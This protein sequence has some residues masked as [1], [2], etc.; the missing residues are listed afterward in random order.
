MRHKL[1]AFTLM[2]LLVG[3]VISTI[4]ISFCYMGYRIIYEQY[5]NYRNI[6]TEVVDAMQFRSVMN[7]DFQK[8]NVVFFK[9]QTLTIVMPKGQ[10]L[11]YDFSD[12]FVLRKAGDAIDTF[13]LKPEN[14]KPGYLSSLY[15]GEAILHSVSFD[16]TVCGEKERFYFDKLYDAETVVNGDIISAKQ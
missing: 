15:S 13:L 12:K 10:L 1:R 9:D 2:E 11:R 5:L 8:S 14:I 6:K 3:M 4:L 16:A 7:N